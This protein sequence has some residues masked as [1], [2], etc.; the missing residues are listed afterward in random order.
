MHWS[1][2]RIKYWLERGAA[3]PSKPVVKLL[4]RVR[5]ALRTSFLFLM[6]SEMCHKGGII[7]PNS[8]YH[9]KL[10]EATSTPSSDTDK[11]SSPS[12]QPS[13]S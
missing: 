3:L 7:P 13:P 12:A 8:K 1:A 5:F 4:E 11:I 10:R 9:P 2:E 6:C